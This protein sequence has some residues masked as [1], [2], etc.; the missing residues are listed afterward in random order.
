MNRAKSMKSKLFCLLLLS[1]FLASCEE[2]KEIGMSVLPDEDRL[3]IVSDSFH[4]NV[5]SEEIGDVYSETTKPVLGSYEDEL[6]GSFSVDFLSDFRYVRDFVFPEGTVSD[7]LYLVMYYRSFMGDSSA[8]QEATAYLID[9]QSLE[10]SRDYTIHT[11]ISGICSMNEVLGK[12][13]Y[14]AYDRTVSDSIRELADYCDKVMIRLPSDIAAGI[15]ADPSLMESQDNFNNFFKG[16]YVRNTYG[17]QTILDIDSVNLELYYRYPPD[18]EK[19]DSLLYGR[20]ILPANLESTTF[21]HVAERT[22]PQIAA[23]PDTLVSLSSPGGSVL[24]FR[25]PWERIYDRIYGSGSASGININH[26]SVIMNAKDFDYGGALEPPSFI[27]MMREEDVDAFFTQSLYPAPGINTYL[28]MFNSSDSTYIFANMADFLQKNLDGGPASFDNVG[29]IVV[30]PVG[31][32]TNVSGTDA[33][34]Y[35]SMLPSGAVFGSG[36]SKS[37]PFRMVV[38][39]TDL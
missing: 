36:K 30:M 18:I 15:V 38:T 13:A 5:Y 8:V 19:P 27:I 20:L 28:G 37:S 14:V 7:S 26:V 34:I 3:A 23:L 25:L 12:T 24:K 4:I 22:N 35:N 39:Y 2:N 9:G 21:V 11:D 6:F 31:G 1:V 17:S 16:V 33:S 10:F 29:D 32:T